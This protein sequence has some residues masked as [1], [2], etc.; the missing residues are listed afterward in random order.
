MRTLCQSERRKQ[1]LEMVSAAAWAKMSGATGR[2]LRY[3]R[4][5]STT[6]KE[7]RDYSKA[8]AP[9]P[10]PPRPPAPLGW[11]R[12]RSSGSSFMGSM[13]NLSPAL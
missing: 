4:Q 12:K 5:T 8:L 11:G 13:K 1:S 2:R 9:R 7:G 10:P 6:H 3:L